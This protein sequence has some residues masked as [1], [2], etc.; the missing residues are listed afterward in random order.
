MNIGTFDRLLFA[1]SIGSHILI[2][3][4]SIGL[5]V[6]LPVLEYIAIKYKD[7]Y[8]DLLTRRVAKALVMFFAVG[9]ASGAVMAVELIDLFPKFMTII[10][11]VGVLPFYYEIFA[12]F[13]ET[14]MLVSYYY[15]WD[16]FK[17]RM[18][19]WLLTFGVAGGTLA[20]AVFITMINAWMNTPNGF[21]ISYYEKTG[22]LIDVNPFITALTPSTGREVFHVVIVTA[23]AGLMVL[24]AFFAYQYLRAKTEEAKTLY[25]KGL[26][27]TFPMNMFLIIMAGLSGTLEMSGLLTY[28]PEKYAALDLNPYPIAR[29]A[30]EHL[31]G[32]IVEKNGH[33][34]VL[35][36]IKIPFVQS[37]LAGNGNL[38]TPVPGLSQFPTS[39]WPP[40]AVHDTFDLMVIGGT[41]L[42]LF[43][44]SVL[45]AWILKKKPYESKGFMVAQILFAILTI[46]IYI[47]GWVTD[48]VGRQPWIIYNVM[49]VYQAANYSPS[50]IVPGYLIMAFYTILMPF[51]YWYAFRLMKQGDVKKEISSYKMPSTAHGR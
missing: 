8:Y 3:L 42:G 5:S 34:Y 48:E 6:I 13:L 7:V 12:F 21:N 40:L 28:Q 15:Y 22:K 47:G 2:V 45:I 25:M 19:H 14:I 23:F 27:V 31:F 30:P 4:M 38:N 49:T 16:V 24:G 50:I 9:T 44:L 26:K 18:H 39:T 20:S 11:V 36:G 33:Y 1:Y 51:S 17:N 41:L 10:A 29:D 32:T 37:L 46:P 35:G 43:L